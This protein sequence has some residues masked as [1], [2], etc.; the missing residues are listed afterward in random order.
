MNRICRGGA[1]VMLAAWLVTAGAADL[2]KALRYHEY[3]D[4]DDAFAAFMELAQAGNAAAQAN[5]GFYYDQGLAVAR[6]A[7]EAAR[8]Y[9]LAAEN[10]NRDAQYNLGAL[11]EAGDGVARNYAEAFKWFSLAAAQGDAHA[12]VYLG[13]FY[14]EGLGRTVDDVRA[15]AW[16]HVAAERGEPSARGRREA[17]GRRLSPE[18]LRQARRLGA[19]LLGAQ[20]A[21]GAGA[22]PA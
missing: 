1:A 9:R 16:F 13:L 15:F 8:W 17:A 14:E 4:Y 12:A 20:P 10:G 21:P 22:P 2:D 7:G 11:Y 5:V 19:Q 18:Q 6:D 3:K